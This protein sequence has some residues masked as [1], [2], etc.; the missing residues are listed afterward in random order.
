MSATS[1]PFGLRAV[2]SPSGVVRPQAMTIL[3][4]YAANILQN[5]PV[6]IG[7]NGTIEAAAIGDRFIGTFSGLEFTDS[8]GR[9]SVS[10]KWT[11]SLAATEI[12]AYVT[13]DP[14]MVYEIQS[15]AAI[16]LT[17]IGKQ[18]DFT[19]IGTG[20]T[21]TGLSAMMLDVASSAANASLRVINIAPGV[22]NAIGDTY[23]IVQVQISEHQMVADVAAF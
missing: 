9:R 8:N 20:S 23:V 6:K 14:S 15:N 13:L 17:D 5:Q 19:T 1:A 3:T 7:T 12:V 21:V 11:A 4:A 10:N 22:D 18:Y 2:Y 16:V